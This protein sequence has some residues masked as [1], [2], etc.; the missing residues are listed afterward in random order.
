MNN[1]KNYENIILIGDNKNVYIS[2]FSK[3]QIK[4]NSTVKIIR[5]LNDKLPCNG[6]ELYA[7]DTNALYVV[8]KFL[9][10]I[11]QMIDTDLDNCATIK[12][13][14]NDSLYKKIINGKYK[15]WINTGMTKSGSKLDAKEVQEWKNF[16]EIYSK[17]FSRVEFANTTV[18]SAKQ[19]RYN[20]EEM[21]YG[22][23][24]SKALHAHLAKIKQ[25]ELEKNIME[26][27]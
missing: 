25:Q 5:F 12:L 17:V 6:N 22:Q 23:A 16:T 24:I 27:M 11:S 20:Q 14:V 15:Y 1:L 2:Y 4:S 13:Y 7:K 9:T 10:K 8:N 21:K 3:E 19:F 18:Y 26:N